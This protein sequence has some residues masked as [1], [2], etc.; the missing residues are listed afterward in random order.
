MNKKER[1]EQGY[2]TGREL[3]RKLEIDHFLWHYHYKNG[4]IPPAKK[5][6]AGFKKRFFTETDLKEIKKYFDKRE[7]FERYPD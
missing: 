1:I 7:K 6:L 2:Y 5:K 3:T 4:Y